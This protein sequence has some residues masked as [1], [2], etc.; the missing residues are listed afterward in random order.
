MGL[1]ENRPKETMADCIKNLKSAAI[2]SPRNLEDPPPAG[3]AISRSSKMPANSMIASLC[4][5]T[6]RDRA[7]GD[8]ANK[9]VR[10]VASGTAV[11][12]RTGLRRRVGDV[13]NDSSAHAMDKPRGQQQCRQRIGAAGYFVCLC[14]SDFLSLF[15]AHRHFNIIM[16][17]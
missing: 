10:C 5:K 12:K 11:G 6:V 14:K 9:E 16:L 3:H 4:R 7:P 8:V 2:G 13:A 15:G 1:G 17:Y